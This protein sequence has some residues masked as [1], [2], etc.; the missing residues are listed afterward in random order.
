M[1]WFHCGTPE[2]FQGTQEGDSK[3]LKQIGFVTGL[4]I[5][6][7][8]ASA[9]G[10]RAIVALKSMGD[11]KVGT[12]ATVDANAMANSLRQQ[13]FKVEAALKNLNSVVVHIEDEAQIKYLRS[14]PQ[15]AYVD[16]E[17]MYPAPKPTLGAFYI[18]RMADFTK[19]RAKTNKT[20]WGIVA[21]NARAAWNVAH[22]GAGTRVMI[23]DS[24]IDR[25]H[26]SLKSNLEKG[27]DFVMDGNQPYD[28]ADSIGH[29]THVA[30]TIAAVEESSGFTGIAPEA[31]ILMGRVCSDAGCSSVSI[32]EG[33][34]WA[35]SEKVDLINMS[36]GGMMSPPAVRDAVVRAEKAGVTIVAA[37]GNDGTNRVG[38][39][40]AL[41]TV[42]AVGAVDNTLVRASFS[43]YGPELDVVAPG[44]DVVSSVPMGSGRDS[45]VTVNMGSRSEPV[46]NAPVQGAGDFA[47]TLQGEA[48]FAGLGKEEE[49]AKVNLKGK[50]ALLARGE[51]T[52]LEKV[53][54]SQK[55]GAIAVVVYNNEPGIVRGGMQSPDPITVPVF[56]IEQSVGLAMKAE[57]DAS[58]KVSVMMKMDVSNFSSF[59]GT[60]MASPHAAGVVALIKS[61]N[62]KLTP[63]QVRNLLKK[64]AKAPA[65]DNSKNEYGAG[66][67][68]AGSA[69]SAAAAARVSN[70]H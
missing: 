9:E 54:N 45:V 31:K 37:S 55:A 14:L 39:P 24:G 42:I 38:Y 46:L 34:D 18:S 15:V 57:L 51:I 19:A 7:M 10:K 3:M 35:I 49:V 33:I 69:V 27:R 43:Q 59:D 62:K 22:R 2:G 58:R 8:V 41:P 26:P 32:A 70:L 28:Y 56:I 1:N 30:G 20:P 60:S 11:S 50:V 36:L 13:N 40:A 17:I 53:L 6:S 67:V 68:D 48:V 44:V 25:D 65:G 12:M 66:L 64:T 23:L 5:F 52:F 21:V 47:G 63:A 4:L 16:P 61:T 29:G